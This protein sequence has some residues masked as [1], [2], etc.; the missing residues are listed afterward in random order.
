MR[1]RRESSSG[2]YSFGQ[3]DNNFLTDSP[4]CVAQAVNTRLQLWRGEWF[5]DTTQG[6]PYW[7]SVLGKRP[8]KAWPLILRDRVSQTPGVK[9]VLS[10]ETSQQAGRRVTF[11]ATIDTLYGTTTVTSEA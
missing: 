3:G 8:D 10:V 9:S 7:Q 2:D 6:T 4:E 11:N 1:Y 5:L